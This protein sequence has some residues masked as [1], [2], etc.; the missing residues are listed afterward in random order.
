MKVVNL[1]LEVEVYASLAQVE[2]LEER[3]ADAQAF[4]REL[5]PLL[6]SR[7]ERLVACALMA[8]VVVEQASFLALFTGAQELVV[9]LEMRRQRFKN[10][11]LLVLEVLGAHDVQIRVLRVIDHDVEELH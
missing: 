4:G 10:V 9:S 11:A 8:S 3:L 1:P 6:L 7:Q 5:R 2:I